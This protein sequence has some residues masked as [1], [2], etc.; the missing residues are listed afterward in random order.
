[1]SSNIEELIL[2][3]LIGSTQWEHS[4]IQRNRMT[5]AAKTCA[6]CPHK[7]YMGIGLSVYNMKNAHKY[8][9]TKCGCPVARRVINN[10]CP[11][12]KF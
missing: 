9:C 7:A 11:I 10:N 8:Q 6:S 1:M 4:E 12:K 3:S 2:L 5:A